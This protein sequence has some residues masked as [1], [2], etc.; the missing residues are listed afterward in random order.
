MKRKNCTDIE[1]NKHAVLKMMVDSRHY[2]HFNQMI[3]IDN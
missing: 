2:F 3:I 1:I